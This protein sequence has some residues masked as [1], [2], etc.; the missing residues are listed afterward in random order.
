MISHL[1]QRLNVVYSIPGGFDVPDLEPSMIGSFFLFKCNHHMT[2]LPLKHCMLLRCAPKET[3]LD[4]C[5]SF[6]SDNEFV[7]AVLT[8]RAY[9]FTTAELV[10]SALQR[11][12]NEKFFRGIASM[13]E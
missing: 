3:I 8:C 13:M 1:Q 4:L 7:S 6:P 5:F 2:D 12:G 10:G 11:M 9:C